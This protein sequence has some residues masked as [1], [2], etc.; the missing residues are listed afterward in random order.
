MLHRGFAVVVT[1]AKIALHWLSFD[2]VSCWMSRYSARV[3][4]RAG[5]FFAGLQV[6]ALHHYSQQDRKVVCV[7]IFEFVEMFYNRGSRWLGSGN[8]RSARF[9]TIANAKSA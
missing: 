6:E 8:C 1:L 7:V 2:R 9:T 5:R 4:S 3:I